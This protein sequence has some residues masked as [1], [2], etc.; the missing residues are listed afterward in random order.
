MDKRSSNRN[1]IEELEDLDRKIAIATEGFTTDRLCELVLRNRDKLSAENALTIC[2][3]IIAMKREVNPRLRYKR[4][5]VQFLSELS[6]TVGVRAAAIDLTVDKFGLPDFMYQQKVVSDSDKQTVREI[7]LQIKE[8]ILHV[9]DRIAPGKNCVFVPF[10]E[11]LK[12]QL[13]AQK[14]FDMT[15]ANR[16]GAFLNL[17]PLINI[18]K[19]PTI[20]LRTEGNL[21]SQVMPFALFEDLKEAMFLME[22]ADGVRPY[23]M[24]W[25]YDVFL[26]GF[27]EKDR[28]DFKMVVNPKTAEETKIEEKM[29]ALTTEDLVQKTNEVYNR[30]YTKHQIRDTYIYPLINQGY[31]DETDSELDK[32]QKILYPVIVLEKSSKNER[33]H[34]KNKPLNLF[35]RSKILVENHEIYPSRGYVI[36]QIGALLR[37]V[38]QTSF[39]KEIKLLDDHGMHI[40]ILDQENEDIDIASIGELVT[41]TTIILKITFISLV[42]MRKLEMIIILIKML[43]KSRIFKTPKSLAN[44]SKMHLK[45]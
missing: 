9:S 18:D 6:R 25:Y 30:V 19:R 35:Q 24:E 17:L 28:P 13:P 15:T 14:A 5:T 3:Y 22:Y 20:V 38:I 31:I 43:L 27:N 41:L 4:N 36:S 12:P 42:M 44:L 26:E 2:E 45:M 10:R 8:A 21:I 23:V 37:Y 32:R 34:D 1:Q 40:I 29:I 7:I 16:F 39:L 33:L 11:S